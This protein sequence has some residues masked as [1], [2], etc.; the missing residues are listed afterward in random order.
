MLPA[1]ETVVEIHVPLRPAADLA[2]GEYPYPWIDDIEDYLAER[3]ED[4]EVE[5]YDDGEE[6]G[7]EYVFFV[8]GAPEASL[9]GV[10]AEVA[11]LPFVPDGAYAV[12]TDSTADVGAG[13]RVDL[14]GA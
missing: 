13:R 5:V 1:P 9:V 8:C 4:G 2:P 11:A 6:V 3:S 12:V 14:P 7:P 10:A